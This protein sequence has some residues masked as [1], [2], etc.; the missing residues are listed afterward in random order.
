M[1]VGL[2]PMDLSGAVGARKIPANV[3]GKRGH[4]GSCASKALLNVQEEHVGTSWARCCRGA[5]WSV[6][7]TVAWEKSLRM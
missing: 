6:V 4:P 3:G 2:Y 5:V 1:R 7:G